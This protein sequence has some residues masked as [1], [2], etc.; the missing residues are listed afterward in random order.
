MGNLQSKIKNRLKSDACE[1]YRNFSSSLIPNIDNVLGVRLPTL[2]K[3]A[4]EI[5]RSGKWEEYLRFRDCEFMEEIM[6]Q[7]MVIGLI[8]STPDEI[9]NY[10]RVF[11]PK[12]NNWSVCD[13]FCCGLKFTKANL[14][15]V[16][17]FLQNYLN[18]DKEFEI[19]F[20]YVML[21]TY[22]INDKYIN[23][24]LNQF[25]RFNSAAYYAQMGAAWALCV[26]YAKY[27]KETNAYLQTSKLDKQTIK[28]AYQKIRDSRCIKNYN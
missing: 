18:S 7:G 21:L 25:D 20:G 3:I 9:L 19:R 5:Y 10:M 8:Q 16:W 24:V 1:K 14:E 17:E 22:F 4:K 2:R 28:Y 6:L 11:V 23:C 13:S 27:P 26:C 12:I 15:V